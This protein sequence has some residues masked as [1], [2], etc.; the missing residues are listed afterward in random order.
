MIPLLAVQNTLDTPEYS[1]S[2][3]YTE[4]ACRKMTDWTVAKTPGWLS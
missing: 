4:S 2:M 3:A 1:C